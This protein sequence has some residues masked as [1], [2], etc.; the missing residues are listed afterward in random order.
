MEQSKSDG[1]MYLVQ[2]FHAVLELHPEL[3]GTKY[4]IQLGSRL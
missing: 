3:A 2:Y 1:K 4:E